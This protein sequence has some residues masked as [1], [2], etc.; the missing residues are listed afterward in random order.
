MSEIGSLRL[1]FA[2]IDY[3]GRV[4]VSSGTEKA[5][6]T[7]LDPFLKGACVARAPWKTL[8][9]AEIDRMTSVEP[10]I[11][12]QD[13]ALLDISKDIKSLIT[14]SSFLRES[15]AEDLEAAYANPKYFETTKNLLGLVSKYYSV[16]DSKDSQFLTMSIAYPDQAST[17][18]A[19]YRKSN[20]EDVAAFMG[21]HLDTAL[22]LPI[23]ELHKS[24]NRICINIGHSH[25]YVQIIPFNALE[26]SN[27]LNAES[28]FVDIEQPIHERIDSQF[29]RLF[30]ETPV[31]RVRINPLEAYIAATDNYIH[32]GSTPTTPNLDIALHFLGRFAPNDHSFIHLP[33]TT[34]L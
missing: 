27:K 13:F 26:I 34:R 2:G 5:T 33:T 18:I 1:K 24:R 8:N 11:V 9:S 3:A 22:G 20:G 15:N 14:D 4:E 7:K 25:R 30:P 6:S 16:G 17:A 10:F 28:V 23:T 29:L 32:D 19:N 12:G 31:Y 21:L